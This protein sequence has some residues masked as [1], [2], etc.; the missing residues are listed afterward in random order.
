MPRSVRNNLPQGHLNKPETLA[1]YAAEKLRIHLDPG[2]RALLDDET[3]LAIDAAAIVLRS[4][5]AYSPKDREKLRAIL[6]ATLAVQL[7]LTI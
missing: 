5:E 4:V 3:R 2:P 7:S 1:G 6:R